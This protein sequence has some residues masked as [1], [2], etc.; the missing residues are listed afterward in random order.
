MAKVIQLLSDWLASDQSDLQKPLVL[1]TLKQDSYMIWNILSFIQDVQYCGVCYLRELYRIKCKKCE[2]VLCKKCAPKLQ[3]NTC[4]HCQRK[5]MFPEEYNIGFKI[6]ETWRSRRRN[7]YNFGAW[8]DNPFG[9]VLLQLRERNNTEEV[10]INLDPPLSRRRIRDLIHPPSR[11][12]VRPRA[13]LIPARRC[14]RCRRTS[15]R[16]DVCECYY[17]P[18]LIDV[19]RQSLL[20]PPPSPLLPPPPSFPPLLP[21]LPPPPPI[22]PPPPVLP[23]PPPPILLPP[24]PILAWRETRPAED[25]RREELPTTMRIS[26]RP[27][28]CFCTLR[29]ALG[30][31]CP[32]G[33]NCRLMS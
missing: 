25:V 6:S 17:N 21:L 32:Y 12:M 11:R 14:I 28:T 2:F 10:Q 31:S 20:L 23:P 24:V 9:P 13:E 5:K 26:S 22:L 15:E 8:T 18:W 1:P 3:R 19:P 29:D 7:A 27:R 16:E 30:Y 4:P 33:T